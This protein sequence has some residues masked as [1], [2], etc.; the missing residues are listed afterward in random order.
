MTGIGC[1]SRL[2]K[3]ACKMQQALH[4]RQALHTQ[5][6]PPL[7]TC[8]PRS[9]RV[10]TTRIGS[11][12]WT[13]SWF[14]LLWPLWVVV[15]MDHHAP[16]NC[17]CNL[18]S[19]SAFTIREYPVSIGCYRTVF[20][21][22]IFYTMKFP[23]IGSGRRLPS[24]PRC[25]FITNH[26]PLR[27]CRCALPIA[28]RSKHHATAGSFAAAIAGGLKLIPAIATVH[29]FDRP[30][31]QWSH[32]PVWRGSSRFFS[33]CLGPAQSTRSRRRFKTSALLS[34]SMAQA[35]P[36]ASRGRKHSSCSAERRA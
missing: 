20:R 33:E 6:G 19:D 5:N 32:H 21:F 4:T 14:G 9:P 29:F 11:F 7:H 35:S 31:L 10:T 3:G 18:V 24:A 28:V 17:V 15:W 8:S 22:N 30:L 26:E 1:P 12:S 16:E 2:Q 34:A 13:A 25:R 23:A 27:R 36:S